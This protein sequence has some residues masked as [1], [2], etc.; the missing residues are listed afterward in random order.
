M[1]IAIVLAFAGAA[2][3]WAL[4]G[5]GDVSFDG[6]LE[7]SGNSAN[8]ETDFSPSN[9]HRGNTATRVRLGM[10]AQITEG[11]KGR[12]EA[13]RDP[14]LY[15]NAATTVT[16]EEGL[17]RFQNAYAEFDNIFGF[18]AR[19]GRQYV[20]MPGD[21]VW[22]ISPRND[23]SLTVNS[24][25]G[26][27]VQCRHFDAVNLDLFLGKAV[28]DDAIANTDAGD[29]TGDVNMNSLQATLPKVIPN[30]NIGIGYLF[31]RDDNAAAR[32]DDNKLQ[33]ARVGANGGISENMFTYRAEYL[34][35]MGEFKGMGLTGAGAATD[36]DYEGTAIDIGLGFNPAETNVG[37]FGVWFNWLMASG[38]D[39]AIDDKDESFHDFSVFG[40]V[41]P[42]DRLLG[43]I[44]GKSNTL[45]GGTP[46]GQG[47]DTF[48]TAGAVAA[49]APGATTQGQGLEVIN[50]GAKYSPKPWDRVWFK[51]DY[52]A[53]SRAEDSVKTAAAVN[54]KVGDDFG[55]EM[56]FTVGYKHTDNVNFKVGY[57]IFSPD[58]ALTG[59]GAVNDDN[60]TKLFART[61]IK[62]GGSAE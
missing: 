12:I 16:T 62:W 42:S 53:F 41:D 46:L 51:F 20:G 27:L 1:A 4:V 55:S 13:V 9:D 7:V 25:T 54:T 50:I 28:E 61:N 31:G 32:S 3:S 36:L 58:D 59:V 8:N 23:D 11:V 39:N 57:A 48:Q 52:F 19:L 26:L 22:N 21:L 30:G 2:K 37:T 35:N 34:M 43:E 15:G 18:M 29:A 44:F 10:N 47:L 38:D 5:L 24:I 40:S 33:I 45:G 6:S 60:I 14:R 17:W 56:D 49:A